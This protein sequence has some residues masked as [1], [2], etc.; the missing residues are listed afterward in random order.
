MHLLFQLQLLGLFQS[1][2]MLFFKGPLHM[3]LGQLV[4]L[5][6]FNDQT[7]SMFVVPSL[8][9][10]SPL[11]EGPRVSEIGL[12]TS[13]VSFFLPF[14]L[15][16]LHFLLQKL[17]PRKLTLCINFS[18][19]FDVLLWAL[20]LLR[21]WFFGRILRV[22]AIALVQMTLEK[23]EFLGLSFPLLDWLKRLSFLFFVMIVSFSTRI[24]LSLPLCSKRA[25]F[26][27]SFSPLSLDLLLLN[28]FLLW[29]LLP[30]LSS[31]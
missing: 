26:L 18:T 3:L 1:L 4:L 7:H 17:H 14:F 20:F 28:I 11:I 29:V 8:H 15:L 13:Y 22:W 21:L 25:L 24:R 31:V 23:W 16:L 9:F 12:Q 19:Q 6:A 10:S 2:A 30:H 5:L 27:M